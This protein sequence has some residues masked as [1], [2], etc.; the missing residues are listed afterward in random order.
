MPTLDQRIEEETAKIKV[1]S[2]QKT[3]SIGGWAGGGRTLWAISVVGAVM[4]AAIGL[5]APLFPVIVGA[6]W[7]VLTTIGTSVA[8][9]AATGI[10]LG[11]GGGLVLGRISGAAAAV[12]EEQEKRMKEWMVRQKLADNPQA[13]ILPDAP[14]AEEPKKPFWQ[15]FKDTYHTYVN[16]RVGLR[17]AAIGAIGGLIMGAAFIATGGV[18]GFAV[19]PALEALTGLSASALTH[20]AILAYSAGVVASFGALWSFNFPKITSNLTHFFGELVN[21][22]YGGREWGPQ[23]EKTPE[24]AKEKS[25]EREIAVNSEVTQSGNT[26]Q[27]SFLSYK[28]LVVQHQTDT[29]PTLRR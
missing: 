8:A 17:F 18:A 4:G 21:G 7:P 3:A 11:F 24:M 19:M 12:G 27:R 1:D 20:G 5:V 26:A 23:Q 13:E 25:P 29:E 15:R 28:E 9:F 6:A 16:P 10:S 14:K 2:Y 22:K